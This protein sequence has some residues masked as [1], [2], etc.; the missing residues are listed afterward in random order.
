ML[1]RLIVEEPVGRGGMGIVYKVRDPRSR[2]PYAAKVLNRAVACQRDFVKRFKH[3]AK[4]GR[5][6]RHMSLVH[7]FLIKRWEGTWF[8]LMELVDGRAL[9]E[10][11]AGDAMPLD[12][13]L[14]ILR[15]VA[16]ALD[17][18]HSKGY[19]HRDI[20]PDNVL[21]RA[22]G[23][24]KIIDFGLSQKFGRVARTRAGEV[25]GTAKYMAPELINGAEAS[26]ATD[27]YALGAM[28]YEMIAGR[29]PFDAGHTKVIM[30]MHLY[31]KPRP[32]S[33]VVEGIDRNLSAMVDR[34][35]LKDPGR[36]LDSARLIQ[37]LIEMYLTNCRFPDL[38]KRA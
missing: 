4:T 16:G 19:V 28:A 37:S 6:L 3:E 8:Y 23:Q 18:I 24:L 29:A 35:L 17:Y 31:M 26:P 15:E 32:L 34:M 33:E 13:R 12:R 7:V 2:L 38:P 11:A 5:A 9:T 25:M 30:D 21:I 22:D 27:I 36:R 1:G 10:M 14:D 20:K